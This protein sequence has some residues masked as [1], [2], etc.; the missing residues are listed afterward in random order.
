M[1]KKKRKCSN[2]YCFLTFFFNDFRNREAIRFFLTFFFNE[3]I[4]QMLLQPLKSSN[5]LLT[6]LNDL[7]MKGKT[8]KDTERYQKKSG[9]A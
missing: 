7:K 4:F 6:S 9:G 1:D 3:N 8:R 5:T 2:F